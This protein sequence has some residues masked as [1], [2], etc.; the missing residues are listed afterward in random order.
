MTN[1]MLSVHYYLAFAFHE[2]LC[3]QKD[4]QPIQ[5]QFTAALHINIPNTTPSAPVHFLSANSNASFQLAV[6]VLF[7]KPFPKF[8]I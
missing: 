7:S 2:F 1:H 6:S 8:V 4:W 3:L 5:L